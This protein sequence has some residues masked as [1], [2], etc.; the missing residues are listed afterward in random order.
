MREEKKLLVEAEK[1][2]KA[3]LK[4]AK[5]AEKLEIEKEKERKRQAKKDAPKPKRVRKSKAEKV[6]VEIVTGLT[7][8]ESEELFGMGL[9]ELDAITQVE[10][11]DEKD[12]FGIGEN[13][14]DDILSS[15]KY[16]VVEF[17]ETQMSMTNTEIE[18]E[19]EQTVQP[20]KKVLS[21][22]FP[23]HNGESIPTKESKETRE[24]R[25]KEKRAREKLEKGEKGEKKDKKKKA[26]SNEEEEEK[27]VSKARVE[28]RGN[29]EYIVFGDKEYILHNTKCFREEGNG[30]ILVGKWI[31]SELSIEYFGSKLEEKFDEDGEP[32]MPAT[33]MEFLNVDHNGDILNARYAIDKF[34]NIC[35]SE[36]ETLGTYNPKLHK[37]FI[38]CDSE[39]EDGEE[40]QDEYDD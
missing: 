25:E 8:E 4:L 10:K 28:K 35:N 16:T 9:E 24:A 13:E 18:E 32:Y 12:I 6:N 39:G 40:T 21:L 19:I 26:K 2:R 15:P 17:P 36:G 14:L 33:K 29:V 31:D 27:E 22:K 38:T 1:Q 20:E 3:E 5:M 30:F 34:C 37:I 11:V 7:E 23:G